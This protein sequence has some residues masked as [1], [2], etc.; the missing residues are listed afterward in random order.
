VIV[1]VVRG[2]DMRGVMRYLAGPGRENE[3]REPHL[4]AGDGAVMTWWDDT[5]LDRAAAN[6][7]GGHLDRP[8]ARFDVDVPGGHVWHCPLSVGVE[9][10]QLSYERWGRIA[11]E[12]V[13]EM[14]FT[15]ASG[16]AGCRWVA[17]RHGLSKAGNDH[18]HLVVSLVRDDGTKASTWHDWKRA[19]AAA[20]VLEQRHGLAVLTSRSEGRGAPGVTGAELNK[21]ARLGVDEPARVR[22]ARQ[23]RGF[24]VASK[25]EAEFVRRARKEG[26]LIRP[27]FAAGRADVVLGYS[28]AQRPGTGERAVLF[29]GGHLGR[30][31]SLP[32]LRQSWPDTPDAAGAAVAEWTAAARHRRPVSPGRETRVMNPELAAA[33]ARD[34][35]ALREALRA[36]PFDDRAGWA[37]VAHDTAGVFGAW[38]SRLE[39]RPGP[40]AATADVLARSAQLRS[41]YATPR[42]P[43]KPFVGQRVAMLL[44]QAAD[45]TPTAGKDAILLRQLVR[46]AEAVHEAVAAAG[47]AREAT[48]LARV[49]RDQLTSVY[50]GTGPLTVPAGPLEPGVLGRSPVTSITDGAP[51]AAEE[52]SGPALDSPLPADIDQQTADAVRHLRAARAH[53]AIEAAAALPGSAP[54][55]GPVIDP[56]QTGPDR[57]V[58]R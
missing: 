16:K 10:G 33:A 36:V 24:A 37:R 38:S 15:E 45:A 47:N 49:I 56:G 6:T 58:Q 35:S 32:R 42:Q 7:I 40:L 50:A 2:S 55:A 39:P 34:I 13:E 48:Q 53:P 51:A 46:T 23:V 17:V 41:S 9:D 54:T 11:R 52:R 14:G 31:L 3:H 19:S 21:T 27:R 57:G 29:G 20:S 12:F 8:R 44:L 22:L 1:R 18:V 43:V 5:V 28:V 4:V 26:L 30:D 25:D